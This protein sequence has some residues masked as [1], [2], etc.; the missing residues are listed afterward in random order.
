MIRL[1]AFL[2]SLASAVS[3][4]AGPLHD[5]AAAG[6]IS[7]V[8]SLIAEDV[9]VNEPKPGKSGETPLMLAAIN[10][11]ALV[12]KVLAESGA[13]VEPADTGA[14]TPLRRVIQHTDLDQPRVLEVVN[15]LLASGANPDHDQDAQGRTPLVWALLL[16]EKR[17]PLITA[18]I[19]E[20]L[21]AAGAECVATAP[22]EEGQSL[23]MRELAKQTGVDALRVWDAHCGE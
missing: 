8:R 6:D 3:A 12:V 22:S 7:T 21:L 9:D 17:M 16:A 18:G 1:F 23:S 14:P 5:A 15:V 4:L 11:Q 2:I 10:G 20:D 13:D 19:I